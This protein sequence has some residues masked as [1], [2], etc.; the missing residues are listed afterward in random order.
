[1][2]FRVATDVPPR[3]IAKEQRDIGLQSVR[4]DK[5]VCLDGCT[6]RSLMKPLHETPELRAIFYDSSLALR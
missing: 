1:M 5:T 4:G 3:V 6:V 2:I